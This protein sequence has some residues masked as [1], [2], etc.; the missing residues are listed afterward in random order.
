[1][2]SIYIHDDNWCMKKLERLL[3]I[4]KGEDIFGVR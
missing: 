2:N 3:E 4:Y 1:M